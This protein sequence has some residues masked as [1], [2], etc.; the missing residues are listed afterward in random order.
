MKRFLSAVLC[1]A[2]LLICCPNALA[3]E[4]PNGSA[5]VAVYDYTLDRYSP[6]QTVPI[7]ALELNGTEISDKIPGIVLNSRTLAPL[8]LLAEKMGA[9]VEWVPDAA[10]VVVRLG[11]DTI[12]LT[13]GS[14][15]AYV[16]GVAQPLPD[17]VP[18]TG[19]RYGDQGYTM[20]PLRFFSETFHCRVDWVQKSYT[21]CVFTP[22]YV[23]GESPEQ[24]AP[25]VETEPPAE[26]N[27]PADADTAGPIESE[28]PQSPLLTGL[29]AAVSPEKFLICL[30]AGHG[31]KWSGA[32]HEGILEKDLTISMI[33]KLNDI[34]RAKG[35]NTLLT[36]EEDENVELLERSIIANEANADIFVSI[37]CNAYDKDANVQ[38]LIVFHYPGSERGEALAKSIQTPACEFTGAKDRG[39]SSAN[40]SVVRESY[41]PA[42]LVETG[43]MTCHEE[44]MRLVDDT[45]QTQIARGVAQGI[46]RYLNAQATQGKE[47]PDGEPSNGET[48]DGETVPDSGVEIPDTQTPEKPPEEQPAEDAA[49]GGEDPNAPSGVPDGED[50]EPP[51]PEGDT[52]GQ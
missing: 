14:D 6:A 52:D 5:T 13:L 36:R 9:E 47:T 19:V 18:A 8:R 3:A 50:Q 48:P 31:G 22:G 1:F 51:A 35:Y 16:N 33:H 4:P 44:L 10:Q 32:V 49:P 7:V 43:F 42:V 45:Y 26:T 15:T 28:Q 25:P 23:S 37:H 46:I 21:A 24:S 11:S 2:L 40:Y 20:V 30:D 17:G 41:M 34:L 38:G 27:T 12:L 39:I 29:D